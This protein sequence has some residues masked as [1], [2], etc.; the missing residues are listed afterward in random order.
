MNSAGLLFLALFLLYYLST[1]FGLSKLFAKAGEDSWKAWV[2]GLNFAVWAKLI[3][4]PM[5]W[6]IGLFVPILNVILWV[7]MLVE[8]AKAFG[9]YKLGQ[10]AMSVLFPFYYLP[11]IG[12]DKEVK[13][14]GA[15]TSFEVAFKRYNKENA[16]AP[17][18][19]PAK[20]TDKA[21]AERH[22]KKVWDALQDKYGNVLSPF[23][24]AA[25]EW[26]DAILF[27][28]TAALIIRALFIEAFIIPTTSMERTLMAGDFLFVSKFH[29]GT[30]MPMA[31]L[32]LPFIHNKAF[33]IQTYTDLV[34]LPYYRLPGL[35]EVKRNDIV[36]FNYPAHDIGGLEDGLG[37]VDVISMK[38][39][40][41]K[42]CVA[43]AGDK[44]E[45]R[46]GDVFIDDKRGWD[47]PRLQEEYTPRFNGRNLG[48]S[49]EEMRE[50]GFRA[51]GGKSGIAAMYNGNNRNFIQ[52]AHNGSY[53]TTLHADKESIEKFASG[54]HVSEANKNI[55]AKGQ[56]LNPGGRPLS[57]DV[58]PTPF[59]NRRDLYP[60]YPNNTKHSTWNIDNFGPIVIPAKGMTVDLNDD[61]N[62]MLYKRVI[63]GYEGHELAKKNGKALLDGKAVDSYT[64]EDDYYFMMGDNRH[65]SEDSRFW[66]FVPMTHVIGRP[67]FI[68]MSYESTFGFRFD[69]IG[70]SKIVEEFR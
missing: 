44:F 70:T 11:K 38:E 45:I 19:M 41:V 3:G 57:Y 22:V 50:M 18:K 4:K 17:L 1:S 52:R 13:Y 7:T 39:N 59:Y 35:T 58:S 28:G 5:W 31:P 43:V 60:I 16:E 68:F 10:H 2:P 9:L 36:V 49:G 42:R 55:M 37:T 27:A 12:L 8:L 66:G 63:E 40:Y 64:F 14:A 46:D 61:N 48:Y 20:N 26:G 51:V 24:S 21:K 65:Q 29:Y 54:P 47:A 6:A 15:P 34:T 53:M 69:R 62:Y 67:L 23:N 33:G 30:R 32:S 56:A 25:R